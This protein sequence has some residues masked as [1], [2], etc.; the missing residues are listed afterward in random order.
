MVVSLEQEKSTVIMQLLHK[1]CLFF[2]L[3]FI[4]KLKSRFTFVVNTIMVLAGWRV[5]PYLFDP[6][7]CV[8]QH[9]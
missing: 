1:A 5:S 4:V 8:P 6:L 7:I 2:E 3:G 9:S